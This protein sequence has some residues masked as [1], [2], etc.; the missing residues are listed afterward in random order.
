MVAED[1]HIE[2]VPPSPIDLVAVTSENWFCIDPATP[3]LA[4]YLIG[5]LTNSIDWLQARASNLR[6]DDLALAGKAQAQASKAIEKLISLIPRLGLPQQRTLLTQTIAISGIQR[7]GNAAQPKAFVIGVTGTSMLCSR[8]R[9][10]WGVAWTRG[11]E[12][13]RRTRWTSLA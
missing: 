3:D 2:Q 10:S 9:W 12:R 13:L 1:Q 8:S 11:F 7:H 5:R 6:P 4:A